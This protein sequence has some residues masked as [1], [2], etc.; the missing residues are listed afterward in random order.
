MMDRAGPNGNPGKTTARGRTAVIVAILLFVALV[1]L[2]RVGSYLR[3]SLFTLYYSYF[4]DIVVP[5]AMYFLICLND[6]YVRFLR[7][8]RVKAALVFGVASFAEVLQAF[9]VPLLG[10]TFDP[11]DFAMF[12]GGVVLAVLVERFLLD[13]FFPRPA[14]TG[15][16][17]DTTRK[18][19]L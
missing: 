14:W 4:S 9:G 12:G 8:W 17:P 16:P 13:R 15:G 3:G 6:L 2:F 5:F 18:N 10:Q 11:L 19:P 7:D 1:H